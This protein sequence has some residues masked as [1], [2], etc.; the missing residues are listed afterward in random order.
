MIRSLSTAILVAAIWGAASAQTAVV[1]QTVEPTMT[2]GVVEGD[3]MEMAVEEKT[4]VTTSDGDYA[5]STQ[6]DTADY[7][8]YFDDA[9]NPIYFPSYTFS[10]D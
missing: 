7:N 5:S 4:T 6:T 2:I 9:G 3:G 1:T 8:R 10:L